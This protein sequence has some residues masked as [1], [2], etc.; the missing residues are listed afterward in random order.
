M[1]SKQFVDLLA[2]EAVTTEDQILR[3]SHKDIGTLI[4]LKAQLEYIQGLLGF[5]QHDAKEHARDDGERIRR[6]WSKTI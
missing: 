4:G 3:T 6:D 5:I 2:H 1:N